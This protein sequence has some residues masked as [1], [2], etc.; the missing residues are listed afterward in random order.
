MIWGV[1]NN[2]ADKAISEDQLNVLLQSYKDTI[3]MNSKI[4]FKL[5]GTIELQKTSCN[6]VDKLCEKID[7]HTDIVA[8]SHS[9]VCNRLTELKVEQIRSFESMKNRLYIAFGL[10]GTII[11]AILSSKFF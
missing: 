9:D 10:M 11:I 5:D 8:K 3:E 4:M 6:N 2:M 7:K 1:W